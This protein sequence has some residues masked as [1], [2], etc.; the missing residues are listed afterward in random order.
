[1]EVMNGTQPFGWGATLILLGVV[2]IAIVA[3]WLWW[4]RPNRDRGSGRTDSFDEADAEDSRERLE[5]L[6][7]ERRWGDIAWIDSAFLRRQRRN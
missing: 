3:L 5:L 6:R 7:T 4:S 1:M 2:F